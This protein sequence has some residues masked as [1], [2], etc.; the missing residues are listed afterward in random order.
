MMTPRHTLLALAVALPLAGCISFGPE[1]P[2]RL[3]VLTATN[4]LPAGPART[5]GDA[6]A[7]AIAPISAVPALVPPR[8]LVSDGTAGVAYIAKD[9]W[10]A[11]PAILFRGLLAETVTARTGRVV[12]DPRLQAVTPDTRLSG[13][14]TA[15]G[16]DAPGMA[17]VVV[18]DATI[19]RSGRDQ[20]D[21][22][23]FSARV[24]V[25]A[26]D[27]ATVAAAINQAANQVAG[28]VADWVGGSAG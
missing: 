25:S 22:R 8:I 15:F 7:V 16:L 6:Q 17:A 11:A 20:I 12:P 27:G 23:R 18:F 4:A 24:P 1:P 2:D 26:Q 13:Q 19:A 21:Y 14:L 28:D 10:A 3:M 9:R 5:A